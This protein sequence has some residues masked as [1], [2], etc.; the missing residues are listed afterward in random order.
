MKKSMITGCLA[1]MSLLAIAQKKPGKDIP[2][3]VKTS[4]T[5]QYPS[6]TVIKW[7]KEDK[8]YEVSFTMNRKAHSVLMNGAGHVIES[9]VAVESSEL[10]AGILEYVQ[11]N[12]TGQKIKE[13]AQIRNEKGM[14]TYEV[15]ISNADLI[16]DSK[17]V[18]IKKVIP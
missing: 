9:E 16:F 11:T 10:P 3:V 17:G 13:L 7:D 5:Q 8:N 2:A 12:Y 6:A 15:E 4:F 14:L 18:F 1:F